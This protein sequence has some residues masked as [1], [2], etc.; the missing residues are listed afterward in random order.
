MEQYCMRF[1]QC[2]VGDRANR[3][4]ELPF[5]AAFSRCIREESVEKYKD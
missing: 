3:S 2:T 5:R 4:L 1:A